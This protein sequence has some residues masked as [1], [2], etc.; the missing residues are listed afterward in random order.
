MTFFDGSQ[1]SPHIAI[2]TRM[3]KNT[4]V[5]NHVADHR[6]G[7]QY[8]WQSGPGCVVAVAM[9]VRR[10]IG[11][12]AGLCGEMRCCTLGRICAC[13]WLISR[14]F[15]SSLETPSSRTGEEYDNSLLVHSLTMTILTFPRMLRQGALGNS[16]GG[17]YRY[18]QTAQDQSLRKVLHPRASL[19]LSVS[20]YAGRSRPQ[21]RLQSLEPWCGCST[22]HRQCIATCACLKSE[23][24]AVALM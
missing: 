7:R 23:G 24:W 15:Q 11:G 8:L 9:M 22:A 10:G 3:L 14:A 2:R 21:V 6:I 4:R 18:E 20:T 1:P 17:F 12:I 19:Q 5:L 13:S 16:P